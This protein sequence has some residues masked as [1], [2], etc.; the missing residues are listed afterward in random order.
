MEPKWKPSLMTYVP[1]IS[2][3]NLMS[4]FCSKLAEKIEISVI[5]LIYKIK[6]NQMAQKLQNN[7]RHWTI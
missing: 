6:D 5:P 1:S 2:K 4:S 3:P 7:I